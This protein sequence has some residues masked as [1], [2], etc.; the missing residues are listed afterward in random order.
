MQL[1]SRGIKKKEK[2]RDKNDKVNGTES[3]ARAA[4]LRVKHPLDGD[5]P[6]RTRSPTSFSSPYPS[7]SPRNVHL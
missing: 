2:V 7:L 6:S 5:Q 3:G 1:L 4:G